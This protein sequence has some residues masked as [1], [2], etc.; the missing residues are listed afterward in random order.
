MAEPGGSQAGR[1]QTAAERGHCCRSPFPSSLWTRPEVAGVRPGCIPAAQ[2]FYDLI[3]GRR[4]GGLAQCMGPPRDCT[5]EA[6]SGGRAGTAASRTIWLPGERRRSG[7]PGR[8]PGQRPA[9]I[10]TAGGQP[11]G[12]MVL[13]LCPVER[14]EELAAGRC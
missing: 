8:R 1:R 11:F 7:P 6:A 5:A 4:A 14:G 12:S 13:T 9:E 3:I 10:L 2:P